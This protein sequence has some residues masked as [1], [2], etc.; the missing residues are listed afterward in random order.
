LKSIQ[1]QLLV[2]LLGGILLATG[3]AGLAIYQTASK[4]ANE[5][6]DYQLQQ[7]AF[8]MPAR[9]APT[10][11]SLSEAFEQDIIIQIWNPQERLI[12]TSNH[13]LAPPLF[14]RQGFQTVN[15]FDEQ[16]RI[17]TENRRRNIIQIAQP[18]SVRKNLATNLA[19]RSLVPLFL[20]IPIMLTLAGVIV[21]YNLRP[22]E[23]MAQNLRQR[24]ALD[25]QALPEHRLPAELA[26]ITHALNDL[27][28]RLDKAQ[29]AQRA[30]VADAAHELRSP[31]TALKLQL[32]LAERARNETQRTQA[33]A[34]LSERLERAIHLTTQLLT[35]ARQEAAA[36][37]PENSLIALGTLLK[38]AV[39]DS[40][41]LAKTR[42]IKLVTDIPQPDVTLSANADSL[43]ILLKNLLENALHY[44]PAGGQVN[45]QA[46]QEQG[47]PVLRVTDTGCGIP[48]DE[49]QRVFDRFY[50]I[51]DNNVPGTGL[52]L[53]IVQQIAEQHGASVQLGDNPNGQGLRVS[54]VFKKN[55]VA[56]PLL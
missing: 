56:H 31:L 40:G 2:W 55:S 21:R 33:I 10:V 26:T 37:T 49:R 5:L 12:Y 7:T 20:M 29:S 23:S 50:R 43:A 41:T 6:F 52:G 35:L 47:C 16:W 45:L 44:T 9:P 18:L 3:L 4:Q 25:L 34:K 28:A 14:K 48:A 19:L 27:L 39:T 38:Q 1:R 13:D 51:H 53:S 24:T 54:I 15:I 8:S 32:Q 22:L 46:C 42:N 11:E 17:Y 30:F 36:N